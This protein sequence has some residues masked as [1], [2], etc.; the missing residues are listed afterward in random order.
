[1]FR[2]CWYV[3]QLAAVWSL[4]V[5]IYVVLAGRFPFQVRASFRSTWP[6]LRH[7]CWSQGTTRAELSRNVLR[8]SFALPSAISR[9]PE[10]LL[11]RV[12][13]HD[14]H[15]RFTIDDVSVP[16]S[17][18]LLSIIAAVYRYAD[19]HGCTGGPWRVKL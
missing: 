2:A 10:S 8:G 17:T 13:V 4:G 1:M 14:P 11:R 3:G 7:T 9:E 5:L 16:A 6:I 12:L 15:Q 19:I 18:R